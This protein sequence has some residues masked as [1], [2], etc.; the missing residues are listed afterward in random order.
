MNE[1]PDLST[2]KK[3]LAC[4]KYM[5]DKC[6]GVGEIEVNTVY[7]YYKKSRGLILWRTRESLHW[8]LEY[9]DQEF[10]KKLNMVD[11]NIL[12]KGRQNYGIFLANSSKKG[13]VE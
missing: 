12:N 3:I 4:R 11:S 13:Q 10:V 8:E 2:R 9:R 1:D 5:R 7:I 6:L